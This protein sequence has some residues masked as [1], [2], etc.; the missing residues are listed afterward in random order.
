MEK[1]LKIP[2]LWLENE[3]CQILQ[4]DGNSLDLVIVLKIFYLRNL[5]T[6]YTT[7]WSRLDWLTPLFNKLMKTE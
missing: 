1:I 7:F 4:I 2:C 5:S 3:A 6:Y